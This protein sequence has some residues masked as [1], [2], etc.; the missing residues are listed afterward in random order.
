MKNFLLIICLSLVLFTIPAFANEIVSQ[1]E[2][3]SIEEKTDTQRIDEL[4]NRSEK[5]RVAVITLAPRAFFEDEGMRA[6]IEE[7]AKEIFN[8]HA[9]VIPLKESSPALRTYLEDNDMITGNGNL[10]RA[11]NRKDFANLCQMLKADDILYLFITGSAP[12][13]K[14][15]FLS[16]SVK[17]KVFCDA[18]LFNNSKNQY[19]ASKET[20]KESKATA[21]LGSPDFLNVY[22][23]ALN[24]VLD[25]IEIDTSKL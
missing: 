24:K 11:L 23:E 5:K 3:T 14:T 12:Q 18:R 17:A 22:L 1:D 25:E 2:I 10:A 9:F 16:S 21:V 7:K 13:T 4:L 15:S 19:I 6:K 20:I 8:A